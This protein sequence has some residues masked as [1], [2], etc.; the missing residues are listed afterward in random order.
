M[1]VYVAEGVIVV[2]VPSDY[3]DGE[4]SGSVDVFARNGEEW[5]HRAMLLPRGGAERGDAFGSSVA[6]HK[7]T[8]VVGSPWDDDNGYHSG[9][10]RV[11][12]RSGEEWSRKAKLRAPDGAA[13]DEFGWNAAIHGDTIVVGSRYDDGNRGSAHI[14]VRNGEEWVHRAKLSSSDGAANDFAGGSVAIY[15]DTIV[16]GAYGDDGNGND[17]GSAHVFAQSFGDLQ[18]PKLNTSLKLLAPVGA[19]DDWFGRS[20]AIYGDTI[21]V[22]AYGDDDTGDESG[23][24]HVFVR[25]DEEWKHLAK[26][27]APDGAAREYFGRSVSIYQDTIV[28]GADGDGDNGDGNGSAHIFVGSGETWTYEAELLDANGAA[29][30]RFGYFVAIY[31]DT[32]VV[33]AI[34]DDDNGFNSGSAHVFARSGKTWI[35]QAK[36]LAPDGADLDQFGRRVAINENTIV[37]GTKY[38]D[39][40]GSASGS[41]HVFVRSGETWTH[42]AKLLAPDGAEGDEFG[43]S[44]AIYGDTIVVGADGDNSNGDDSGSAHVFVR[45]GETWTHQAKLLAPDGVANDYFGYRVSIYEDTIVV[46]A[47]WDDD[48][49]DFSGSAHVFVRSAD[50]WN[51]HAKLLA[52]DGAVGDEF[53]NSVA[54]YGDAV[55]VGARRDNDNGDDS[56]SAYVFSVKDA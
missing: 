7:N 52:P 3:Y 21:V 32:I 6:I 11:F 24:A 36:L 8:V 54:I 22:G 15:Q 29:G 43:D 5:S 55:V 49:G 23:S 37:V 27:L 17:S 28:V 35:H 1:T 2:G 31:E 45:S 13:G 10:A 40:N 9:S 26:L 16:V 51:H 48:N 44:V 30:D 39:D 12:V 53:G 33:G 25:S 19:A 38:D 46:G 42:Q 41:A 4:N 20:V 47:L 50:E 18:T 34:C 56:G 14:F